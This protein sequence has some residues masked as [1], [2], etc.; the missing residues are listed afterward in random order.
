MIYQGDNW[1]AEYRNRLFTLNFHGRRINQERLELDGS[2]TVGKHEPDFVKFEDP[3]FR[4]IDLDYGPDGGVYILDWA[5]TGECH[6]NDADGVHR[7]T[8]RIYKLTYSG[9]NQPRPAAP[10][11]PAPLA[12]LTNCLAQLSDSALINL[13]LHP[14]E[15]YARHARRIL[16][17]R[18]SATTDLSPL[19]HQISSLYGLQTNIPL[20]LRLLFTLHAVGGD[21][22][23]WLK[24]QLLDPDEHVRSWAVRFL[25]ES[26][27]KW[28]GLIPVFTILAANDPS[29]LVRLNLASALQRAPV[30][31]RGPLAAALLAHGEDNADHYLPLM[32]WYGVEP[33]AAQLPEA[34]IRLAS[35]TRVPLI[36]EYI[37]RRLAEDLETKPTVLDD[38][39]RTFTKPAPAAQADVLRGMSEALR[40][41]RK[42]P[43]PTL[44]D[45]FQAHV[46]K[47]GNSNLQALVRDL[48]VVF[49]DGR[50]L[51]QLRRIA[52]DSKAEAE[53]RRAALRQVIDACPPEL[54]TLLLK[55]ISDR[56]TV[57]VAARGL[58]R[59]DDPEI[60]K[61]VFKHWD[62][63]YPQD[64]AAVVG[65]M[66]A[67]ATY[68]GPLLEAI[69]HGLIPR[70]ALTAFEARQIRNFNNEFLTRRLAEVWGEVRTSDADKARLMA[71]YHALLT[72]ERL[73]HTD[74][75]R[76]REV[77]NQVCA[78]CHRLYGEGAAIGPDLTGGG[79]ANLDYLLENI[80][81]PSAIVPADYRVS[82]VE[83]KDDRSF[84]ALIVS[85]NERAVTIQT[86]TDRLTFELKDVASI[87]QTA[88]SLMPEGLLQGLK[89]DQVCNLLAYLMNPAQAPMPSSADAKEN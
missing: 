40:G 34:A 63:L 39:L 41:W 37:A 8:G 50:A 76:G 58:L 57:G 74:L 13:Q 35:Q 85:Q 38:L 24:E 48:S 62:I 79:R 72:P 42:A 53:S 6:E 77:F 21:H 78:L 49:G 45:A 64:R 84:S 14:N 29:A 5:D 66:A 27:A 1:P 73:K 86:P 51:E 33:I 36:R 52:L 3:W 71:Q 43:K 54:E 17:E 47:T 4:G 46:S 70:S 25:A 2:G 60:P 82:E 55:L 67:R 32:L 89:E 56:A 87:R 69:A 28:N 65:L 83:L 68:A 44:W 61:Q 31:F 75:S 23:S 30:G 19:Q 22:Q 15:W 59:F 81:D 12:L 7:E 18:A 80:L 26:D 16:Q 11:A 20:K 9:P 10:Y 88:L